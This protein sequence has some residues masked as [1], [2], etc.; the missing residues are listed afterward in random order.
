MYLNGIIRITIRN[1]KINITSTVIKVLGLAISIAS[2]IIIWSYVI[3]ENK[4]DKGIPNSDR[5]FRLESQWA[6]MP[7]FLG[8]AMNQDLTNQ[9]KATRLNFWG[10]I[11][12]QVDNIPFN[13][14]NFAF[15]DSTFFKIFP[16]EFIAGNPERALIQPFSLVLTESLAKRLFG[17]TN[18]V[19]KTV[20]F[21][22]KFD[23]NVTAIIRD[24]PF[25]HFKIDLLASMVSLEQIGYKGILRQYDGWSYP[26]YLL[27]PDGTTATE[28]ETKIKGFL[29]KVGYNDPFRLRSF[30]QIYY[31]PEIENESNTKHGNLLYNKILIAVSIFILLL[32]A[33]NFI[34]L[35]IANAVARSK[36][37][38]I[39]KLQGA[40]IYQLI[41]QFVFETV[42]IIFI[43]LVFSFFLLWISNPLL[44]SLTGFPI[45]SAELWNPHNL[46]I[47][48]IGLV[49]FIMIT[50]IYPSL[51]I[52]SYTINTNKE[53]SSGFSNHNGIR[54][55]LIIFQNLVSITLIG[56]TL[57]ANQQFRYMNKKDLGFNKNDIV[58]LKINGQLKDHLDLF[59]EK[60]LKYPEISSISYSSRI[61][62][63]Y[64]G[65]WCCVKI[66][67][68][69]SKYFNNYVDADYLK[70]LGIRIKEGRNF[71]LDNPGDIKATYLINETAIKLYDLKNPIGQII[72][73]GNGIQGQII[74]II[75]DFHYRGLNY[76][77][78]PV[79]LFYTPEHLNYVNVKIANNNIAEALERIKVA[80]SETCPA[81]AFDYNFLDETFNLQYKSEKRFENLLFSFALLALF[82]ASIGLFGLSIYSTERRT[83]EI[84]IRKVNGAKVSEVMAMLN[85]DFVKWIAI[86]FVIATPIAWYAMYKW[87]ENFAYKTELSWWI[88]ALSG[89]LALGI[90]LLTVSWQSW[91]AATRNPVDALRYE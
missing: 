64:W 48:G 67:G 37:V 40:S 66:E 41:V 7:S 26:T 73:P 87:L 13:L 21:E 34:N 17:S 51:Y 81:F 59:K 79:L 82:I 45:L 52:S 78:S 30:N 11:G 84:G 33:I 14:K 50:A 88:F 76:E 74:G 77:Q 60:L 16:L 61:P 9:I 12:I 1:F 43:S 44:S 24:Q 80:W 53:K 25:L 20:R 85:K 55:G 86:A 22:N 72:V 70:T 35:T 36:E 63:N 71:S 27:M 2:V 15:A 29:K 46:L 54:N 58:N 23:F 19:G 28:Y 47:F 3:N 6:S 83:K 75:H 57:I 90:A 31:S 10:D 69:E 49:A 8:H 32:A 4:F 89:L 68:K 62:G 56:C 18:A 38:S 42:L 39:K 65:S 5:I 91:K